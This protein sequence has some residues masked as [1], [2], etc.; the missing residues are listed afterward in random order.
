MAQLSQIELY[1]SKGELRK[2]MVAVYDTVCALLA[3]SRFDDCDQLLEKLTNTQLPADVTLSFFMATASAPR[4]LLPS[5]V[6]SY[7]ANVARITSEGNAE[8]LEALK[9]CK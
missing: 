2:A 4:A 8:V 7:E 9:M 5:R 6:A 1:A 3:D